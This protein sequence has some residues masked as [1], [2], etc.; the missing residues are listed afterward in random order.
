MFFLKHG[1]VC[2]QLYF[3]VINVT[4]FLQ[5]DYNDQGTSWGINNTEEQW[6]YTVCAN[7][8]KRILSLRY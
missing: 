6:I 3:K 8:P 2:K 5:T 7:L 4:F 1:V